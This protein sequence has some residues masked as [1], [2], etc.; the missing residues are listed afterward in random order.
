[1]YKIE[2]YKHVFDQLK[3]P[4]DRAVSMY[5]YAPVFKVRLND[6][7]YILKRTK[8]DVM[9]V[10]K[11]IV[12][13]KHLLSNGIGVQIPVKRFDDETHMIG[14]ERWVIY[15][16]V[17]G[18]PYNGSDV[19]IELAGDLMGR[20]HACNNHTFNHG[21]T[22]KNYEDVFLT[23]VLDD[24]KTIESKYGANIKLTTLIDNAMKHK[25]ED[26]KILDVPYVD[27]TWDYK[28]SNLIYNNHVDLIDLDNSGYIP[29]VF[30]ICLALLLFHTS[31]PLAPNRPFT[32]EEW[33]LFMSSYKKH[34]E[35]TPEE[36]TNFTKFLE[37]VFLDEGLYAIVDL[38]DN[39]QQRQVEFI[40]NLV[41]LDL[42]K[43]KI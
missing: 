9:Q 18:E 4:I 11:L 5:Q 14:E 15:P 16:F 24:L 3:L 36:I 33:E 8:N 7:F 40:N 17:E 25:F 10:N 6:Q 19:H 35:L 28:A 12:F 34:I 22:W 13:E 38:E 31:A 2:D 21:F 27:A 37:F 32:V 41:H 20:I 43:Y 23:D 26:L 39:E 30:E 42:S 1:M 29:R